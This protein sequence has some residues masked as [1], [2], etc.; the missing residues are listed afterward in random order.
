MGSCIRSFM[1]GLVPRAYRRD[2]T[3]AELA[4]VEGLID[5]VDDVLSDLSEE[6]ESLS[7]HLLRL[8]TG[9]RQ[10][11]IS[12]H[13]LLMI[14]HGEQATEP[15]SQAPRRLSGFEIAT[16]L[17][18]FATASSPDE[19][20]LEAARQGE[21]VDPEVRLEQMTRLLESET[22]RQHFTRTLANWL[23]VNPEVA[24]SEE[25]TA[26]NEFINA[27][28]LEEQPFSEFYQGMVTV[29]HVDETTS[30]E[31]FGV[32]GT[33]AF[34]ASHSTYPTPAFITRGVF[35][36]ESLLCG[37]LPDD[38]PAAAIDG[39][40]AT[41]LEIFENHAKQPCATC[42]VAFDSYGAAF[43]QFDTETGLYDPDDDKLGGG[44]E[45][46]EFEGIAGTVSNLSDL[47]EA[48]G[49]SSRAPDCM[50]ELWYRHAVRR[51][52]NAAEGD[53]EALDAVVGA[54]TDTGD[55]SMKSLLRVIVASD[56][57][58]T[59]VPRR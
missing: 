56:D 38:V 39:A 8:R 42:H 57:F 24:S 33:G 48:F 26:L 52:F 46:Y 30:E 6:T 25:I 11:L 49:T 19:E 28:F 35:V 14:E 27:W 41:E 22:G 36:V 58:M 21:L 5:S 18:Y 1:K 17:S 15:D 7:S 20:L 45:L 40:E 4:E 51:G 53:R 54:W 23:G 3:A 16:R 13:F 47:G 50:A 59:L 44:F 2:V 12:P 31:P 43:Q 37:Q 32:L 34:I 9:I 55:T 29:K 10:L